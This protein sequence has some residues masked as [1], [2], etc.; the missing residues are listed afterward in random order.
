[1][2]KYVRDNYEQYNKSKNPF[3]YKISKTNIFNHYEFHTSYYR[4]KDRDDFEDNIVT[5]FSN[6]NLYK[7]FIE[8]NIGLD[9]FSGVEMSRELYT[10]QFYNNIKNLYSY[11]GFGWDLPSLEEQ[12]IKGQ[13]MFGRGYNF[14]EGTLE[15]LLKGLDPKINIIALEIKKLIKEEYNYWSKK[16]LP[17][18]NFIMNINKNGS[19]P[20]F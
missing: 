14:Y 7:K 11:L 10:R 1:M 4:E 19:I 5:F 3:N 2:E 9:Q 16:N 8:K 15:E 18:F 6:G 12:K 13:K 20:N 17:L